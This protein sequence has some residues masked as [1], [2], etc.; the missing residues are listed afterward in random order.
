MMEIHY[1]GQLSWQDCLRACLVHYRPDPVGWALR[2][3]V[4]LLSIGVIVLPELRGLNG[5]RLW[6][7][8]FLSVALAAS[9]WW[10][11]YL[12]ARRAWMRHHAFGRPQS[13]AITPE[14]IQAEGARQLIRWRDYVM[15]REI[16]GLMMLYATPSAFSVLPLSFFASPSDWQAF[17]SLVRARVSKG[18][19]NLRERIWV[20]VMLIL[21]LSLAAVLIATLRGPA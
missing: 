1:K 15:Y 14:G 9:P 6:P 17:G 20:P 3:L 2:G 13:G 4:V 5:A 16:S 7:I 19:R 21:A 11:A 10:L 18:A 12:S 8:A